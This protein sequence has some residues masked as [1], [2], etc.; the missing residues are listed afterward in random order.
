MAFPI[1]GSEKE[2]QKKACKE[3]LE[4][5]GGMAATETSSGVQF[6]KNLPGERTPKHTRKHQKVC[7][8]NINSVLSAWSC[9]LLWHK[10]HVIDVF[11]LRFYFL[12]SLVVDMDGNGHPRESANRKFYPA[13]WSS[14]D[15]LHVDLVRFL[16]C[17]FKHRACLV[18]S[19]KY[20][21]LVPCKTCFIKNNGRCFS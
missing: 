4:N 20:D 16:I 17:T 6:D 7:P 10:M 21:S 19:M 14:H 13:A 2:A 3:E 5:V 12:V 11:Q 18:A 1:T 9:L 15:I 8:Q